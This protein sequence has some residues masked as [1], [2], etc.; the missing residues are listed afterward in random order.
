[1]RKFWAL[2]S[3][4]KGEQHFLFA[5][6]KCRNGENKNK[7][8]KTCP[9]VGS[10]PISCRRRTTGITVVEQLLLSTYYGSGAVEHNQGRMKGERTRWQSAFEGYGSG[11]V[12]ETMHLL[13]FTLPLA[14]N[15]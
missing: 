1:M 9:L 11:P 5:E 2:Q 6:L 12:L 10:C 8:Q 3:I 7:N 4:S 13:S 15:E 14:L